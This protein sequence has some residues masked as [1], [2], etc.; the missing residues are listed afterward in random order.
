MTK[1]AVLMG[2]PSE[3]HAIS[4]K[5]GHG[6]ADALTRQGWLV[7]PIVVPRGGTI[8]EALKFAEKALSVSNTEAVFIALHGCFG[9]DGTVQ[10]LCESLHL[11]YVG[12]GPQAS[13]LGMDKI[14]SRRYFEQAGLVVPRWKAVEAGQSNIESLVEKWAY[15]LVVKP[16]DQGSSIGV[17]FAKTPAEL[18]PAVKAA[19]T[20]SRQVLI[21][22]FVAGREM[23]VGVF[24]SRALP[25]IEIK[26]HQAF[27]D[28]TAKY[29]TGATDYLV[30]APISEEIA[31]QL[32]LSALHAH[33]VL[34]C[35]HM[36]RADFIL[37]PD[38]AAVLLE[39]NT[40]PGFT[41]TS[42]LPK[43]AALVGIDYDALCEQLVQM[44]LAS[45]SS[46]IS[47]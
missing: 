20:F 13:R 19:G 22:E 44:A 7:E 32:R 36:S 16:S 31:G 28:F 17:S 12:S 33:E 42:L 23:T 35:R 3:E 26:P 27:F 24:G 40:I 15:P 47:V 9:E 37:R 45:V 11:P 39:V 41:P 8:D 18:A 34:G 46:R 21:E 1:I 6:V 2:G 43:A 30:P 5:S 10:A 29:T 25:V 38:G 14:A 4:L